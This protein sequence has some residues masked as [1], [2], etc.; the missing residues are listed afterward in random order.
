MKL[1]EAYQKRSVRYQGL[2]EWEGW[3][4]KTY[5]I[6][7]SK[8]EKSDRL[9]A[10]AQNLFQEHT[11]SITEEVYGL[12]FIIVHIGKNSN[13]VLLDWW[14]NENELSQLVFTSDK[15]NPESLKPISQS[16][17]IACVWDLAVIGHERQAWVH[18]ILQKPNNPDIQGYL[19]NTINYD[20]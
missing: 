19:K 20:I 7:Y 15:K 8:E 1:T 16:Q 12:G 18:H 10:A 11:P 14:C 3:R 9:L 17:V 6:Q 2:L 4:M 13:F 5:V